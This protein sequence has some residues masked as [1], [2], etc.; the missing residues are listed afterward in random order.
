MAFGRCCSFVATLI[1][2][3]FLNLSYSKSD[4]G[5]ASWHLHAFSISQAMASGG[6][7]EQ[8]I[9]HQKQEAER[10]RERAK[11]Q[12]ERQREEAK[13]QQ[14]RQREEAERQREQAERDRQ[15]SQQQRAQQ[16]RQRE[17]S[18]NARNPLSQPS[19]NN[20][21]APGSTQASRTN[22]QEQHNSGHDNRRDEKEDGSDHHHE[23]D[24]HKSH[25]D[26]HPPR[27]LVELFDRLSQPSKNKKHEEAK[28]SIVNPIKPAHVDT[29][30]RKEDG[31]E[32]GRCHRL[33]CRHSHV[34]ICWP[35]VLTGGNSIMPALWD[36]KCAPP[37]GFPLLILPLPACARHQG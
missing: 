19:Q 6:G 32:V 11:Q 5:L 15:Q 37:N 28:D 4:P 20:G 24:R 26:D 8:Q 25:D 21:A 10:A 2:V 29:K 12:Q 1:A 3:L 36:L 9:E 16:E 14:E 17:Q 18:E 35:L 7:D 31:G 34:L 23:Y 33:F 27:T 22:E 13:R 30:P